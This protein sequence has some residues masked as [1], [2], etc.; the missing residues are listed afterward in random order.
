M[1]VSAPWFHIALGLFS[2]II[3]FVYL[4]AALHGMY[5]QSFWRTLAKAMGIAFLYG[6]TLG[7]ASTLLMIAAYVML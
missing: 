1:P 6:I 3:A 7:A 5:G 2:L 4:V